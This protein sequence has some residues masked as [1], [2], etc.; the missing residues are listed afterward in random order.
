MAAISAPSQASTTPPMVPQVSLEGC[1]VEVTELPT[2]Q[3]RRTAVVVRR[4][5]GSGPFPVAIHFHGGL[6]TFPAQRLV[7]DASYQ[8]TPNRF[9]AAGYVIVEATFAERRYDPLTEAALHDCLAVV[10]YVKGLPDVD[11]ESVIVWGNSGGGSLAMEIAGERGLGAIAV[12]EPA[13]VLFCGM[14]TPE[15][16]GKEPP[17]VP[18]SGL[19]IQREPLRYYTPEV[20]KRTRDKIARIDCPILLTCGTLDPIN[21]INNEIVIPELRAAGKDLRVVEYAGAPH[22]FSVVHGPALA[23]PF[24]RDCL[25]FFGQHVRTKPAPVD[26]ALVTPVTRESLPAMPVP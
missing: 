15:N 21:Q 24:V 22:G 5:P 17:Y 23:E 6:R 8:H 18:N 1:P 25:S 9:L 2:V 11:A 7:Y 14:Y 4:P 16:L 20:Q 10:D 3:G 13:S 12:E 19:H 26:P